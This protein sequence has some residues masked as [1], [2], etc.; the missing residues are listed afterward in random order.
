MNK[1]EILEENPSSPIPL[2][3]A[4]SGADDEDDDLYRR[5]EPIRT[6]ASQP[7]PREPALASSPTSPPTSP[8]SPTKSSFKNFLHKFRR[9]SRHSAGAAEAEQ[10]GF[11]ARLSRRG[12]SPSIHGSQPQSPNADVN[13]FRAQNSNRNTYSDVSS[14]SSVGSDK[15]GRKRLARRTI[16][17]ASTR[18]GNTEVEEARDGFD[19][20]LAPS[21]NFTTSDAGA[22]RIGSPTRESRFR[23]VGL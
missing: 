21:P 20:T 18:T 16:T 15:E 4:T 1:E 7:P 19:E 17:G 8:T 13:T 3:D 12:S 2:P 14:I 5:P 9:R 23:E 22:A 11:I 10:P 6:P